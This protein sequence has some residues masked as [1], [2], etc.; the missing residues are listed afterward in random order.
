MTY[1]IQEA[2]NVANTISVKEG[3]ISSLRS[4]LNVEADK[5]SL[6]ALI[7]VEAINADILRNRKGRKADAGAFLETVCFD[8][9]GQKNK[10]GKGKKLAE[11]AQK[12][13]KS[14]DFA[15]VIGDGAVAI[16]RTT[17][18]SSAWVNAIAE[19]SREVADICDALEINS[20]NKLVQ[21]LNPVE[22]V[23]DEEKLVA[24]AQKLVKANG[25]DLDTVEGMTAVW[26]LLERSTSA[27]VAI[28]NG[29]ENVTVLKQAA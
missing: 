9:L 3:E 23:S 24:L 8:V 10:S 12:L 17:Q 19:V 22:E 11:N 4:E 14:D 1:L 6:I 5:F 27:A 28:S 13:A 25:L 16:S 7:A 29:H 15:E 18:E 21:H 2:A 20:Y 26:E